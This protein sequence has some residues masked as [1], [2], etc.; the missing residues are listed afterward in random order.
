MIANDHFAAILLLFAIAVAAAVL[1]QRLRLPSTLGYLLV[2]TLVGPHV[3]GLFSNRGEIAALAE[4]G[5][6]FLL[7]TIGL[8]FS[9]PQIYALR[10]L[11]LGLGTGQVVLTTFCVS[12]LLWLTGLAPAAAFVVGAVVAQSSTTVISKQLTEQGE[13]QSRHGRL[14]IALSVFQDVTA[15][16]LIIILPVLALPQSDGLVQPLL[17]ALA[18]GALA[19]ALIYGAGRWLLRPLFHDIATHRSAELFTL[20]VLLVSL[21]AAWITLKLGLSMALGAFLAGMMLGETEFRHQIET[22]IRPFRDVLL[23]LFFVTIGMLLELPGLPAI[24]P[25]ALLAALLLLLSK[26]LVVAP[27]VRLAGIDWQTACRTAMALAVGGEFGFALLAIALQQQVIAQPLAQFILTAVLLSMVLGP[28]LIR[29]SGPLAGYI[30]RQQRTASPPELTALPPQRQP[31][32]VIICG[33]GRIGQNVARL[34]EE[35]EIPFV[36]LDLDA[37]RVAEARQAGEPVIFG[38][39]TDLELLQTLGLE[40]IQ[41]L[42]I[43]HDDLAAALKTLGQVRLRLPQLPIMVRTRDDQHVETLLAAGASEV[44][45]ETIEAG[46]MIASQVLLLA[47][48]PRLRVMRRMHQLRSQRYRL[49]RELIPASDPLWRTAGDDEP[50]LLPVSLPA[51]S[52]AIGQHP[53]ALACNRE[54]LLITAVVRQGQRLRPTNSHLRLQE[55]DVLV[56]YG[57]NE[58]LD[59][60]TAWLTGDSSAQEATPPDC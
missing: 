28:F 1:C 53:L 7:F 48:V 5:I 24:L 8:N 52:P 20:T 49:L 33:Y 40:Q 44:V 43:S 23:G 42:L 45:P 2:G 51:H 22:T 58:A 25:L 21:A 38:D 55:E 47:K 26:S 29:Y 41:L 39:S 50:R 37:S 56:L 60:A 16:P 54:P 3:L 59:D 19:F 6:V 36:A 9:L 15:V 27:L 31:P 10:H 34:L 12:L 14:A 4:F 18:K 57:Q 32:R 35:E 30:Y 46:L 11:L 17:L 13:E